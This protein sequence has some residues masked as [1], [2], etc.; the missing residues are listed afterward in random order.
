MPHLNHPLPFFPC[1]NKVF[2]IQQTLA[3]TRD[4][5]VMKAEGVNWEFRTDIAFI[6]AKA[7][8][9][10]TTFTAFHFLFRRN[11]SQTCCGRRPLLV[12]WYQTTSQLIS[13]FFVCI[14]HVGIS[15]F[16]VYW[17]NLNKENFYYSN[18]QNIYIYRKIST[19]QYVNII[20]YK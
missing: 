20:I 2:F 10:W 18:V 9:L 19:L 7:F 8:S 12:T 1:K 5:R 17:I 11:R 16:S 3:L 14:F 13:L 4:V 15:Y 6:R